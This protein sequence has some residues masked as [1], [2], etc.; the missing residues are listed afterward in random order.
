M[1]FEYIV[2][3][4]MFRKGRMKITVSKIFKVILVRFDVHR[5]ASLNNTFLWDLMLCGLVETCR[6]SS[7]L[8]VNFYEVYGIT[9]KK[10]VFLKVSLVLFPVFKEGSKVLIVRFEVFTG[11]LLRVQVSWYVTL[12]LGLLDYLR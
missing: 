6:H 8:S 7:K 10:M 3:G 1:D 12:C 11:V 2:R 9:S 4:Y 5:L